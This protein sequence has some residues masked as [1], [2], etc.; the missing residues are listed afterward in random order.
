MRHSWRYDFQG[1][2]KVRRW[3]QSPIG[4]IFT[5]NIHPA[6]TLMFQCYIFAN[7]I[8]YTVV[9][10]SNEC[11]LCCFW[12]VQVGLAIKPATSVESVVKYANFVDTLLVMTVEP[13]FG[14]QKFMHDMMPKVSGLFK[15]VYKSCWCCGD[16]YVVLAELRHFMYTYF[17]S[18]LFTL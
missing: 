15:C 10:T 12:I 6:T 8:H 7:G 9:E 16:S 3:P 4:T 17:H 2:I 18:V 1:Q 13:G 14:G 11:S 5:I